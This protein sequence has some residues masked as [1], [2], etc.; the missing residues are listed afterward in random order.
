MNVPQSLKAIQAWAIESLQEIQGKGS[1][2][3][4]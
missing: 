1:P 3:Q 4:A 2:V